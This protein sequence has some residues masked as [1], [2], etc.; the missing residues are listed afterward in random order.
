MSQTIKTACT[1]NP[2]IRDYKPNEG[3]KSFDDF[4]KNKDNAEYA[5]D[6]FAHNYMTGGMQTLFHECLLRLSGKS[7]QAVFELTQAMG[8]GKTHMM[9]ALAWLAYAPEWRPRVLSPALLERVDC[10][11]AQLA[12]YTGRNSGGDTFVWE[13]L[14][15]QLGG[16]KAIAPYA[17][18]GP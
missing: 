10:G 13:N 15:T 3:V 1:F 12:L 16:E 7:D 11:K 9:L 8:G 6:F 5:K 4:L 2:I 17:M 14:A 18:H